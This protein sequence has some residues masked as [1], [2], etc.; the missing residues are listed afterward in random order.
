MVASFRRHLRAGNVSERGDSDL[1]LEAC[2]QL[3][4]LLEHQGKPMHVRN[5]RREHVETFVDATDDS[6]PRRMGCR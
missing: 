5:I 3:A 2:M 6:T 1:Y 4:G